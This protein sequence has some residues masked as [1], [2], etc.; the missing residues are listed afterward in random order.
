MC[1][2]RSHKIIVIPDGRRCRYTA[3]GVN[4]ETSFTHI[5]K[6]GV[7]GT[8]LVAIVFL[9]LYYDAQIKVLRSSG[10]EFS[11]GFTLTTLKEARLLGWFM[12]DFLILIPQ[13]MPF[14][15]F[16]IIVGDISGGDRPVL[17]TADSVFMSLMFL[18]LWFLPRFIAVSSV[19]RKELAFRMARFY[20]VDI[21]TW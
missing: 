4:T 8:T 5:L 3:V 6:I 9:F 18:R 17:Y 2:N 11:P 1:R 14:L 7:V 19:L 13:P 15:H 20:N 21:N 10:V 12:A 16:G